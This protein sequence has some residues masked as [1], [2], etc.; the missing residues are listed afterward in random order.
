MKKLSNLLINLISVALIIGNCNQVLALNIPKEKNTS[1]YVKEK[2]LG[3]WDMQTIVTDS[4]CPFVLKGT[5]TESNLEIVPIPGSESEPNIL[6][7]SWQGGSWSKSFGTLKILN[8]N[9]AIAERVT[10]FVSK[11]N[12]NWKA[13]LVDHLRLSDNDTIQSESIVIQYKNNALVGKYKT[14]SILTKSN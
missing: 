13:I 8:N 7:T 3:R 14:Y 10:E 4:N 9:E 1:Y 2:F 6:K 12:N 5:T 11:D